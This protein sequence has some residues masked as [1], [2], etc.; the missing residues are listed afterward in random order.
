MEIKTGMTVYVTDTDNSRVRPQTV[1]HVGK[2]FFLTRYESENK[3]A[4][5]PVRTHRRNFSQ[6]G[7]TIFDTY[8]GAETKLLSENYTILKRCPNCGY[9]PAL[10]KSR[11]KFYYEC[12]GDCWLRTGKHWTEE[13]AKEE[14]NSLEGD[15]EDRIRKERIE[16]TM[17][18]IDMINAS[19][20]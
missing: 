4:L 6:L 17:K 18:L 3:E 19:F 2:D 13:E 16:R 9:L 5:V 12:D 8:E 7:V 15:K 10:H 11:K 14:W 20:E 1:V